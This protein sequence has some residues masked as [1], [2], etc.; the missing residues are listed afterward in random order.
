MT[1]QELELKDLILISPS[2]FGDDRGFFMETYNKDVFSKAGL[3]ME[4]VQDNHSKSTE[5]VLRGLHFQNPPFA[6]GKL[7]RV[8]KGAIWDVVVDLR[9]SS[10][11]YKK[12]AKVLLNDVDKRMLYVPV[13]FAHGFVSIEPCEVQYKCTNVYNKASELGIRWDDSDLAIDWTIEN[14]LVSTKDQELP[15]LRDIES[16]LNF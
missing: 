8:T 1:F 10:P 9:K 5:G 3:T 11:T 6:Q 7:V 16:I 14:P 4:F 12:V 15:Y 2:V 13:G